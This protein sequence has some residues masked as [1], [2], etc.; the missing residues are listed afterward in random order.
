[1]HKANK[2][3]TL[4]NPSSLKEPTVLLRTER[5]WHAGHRTRREICRD[6]L[7]KVFLHQGFY[8]I[9]SRHSYFTHQSYFPFGLA[10]I[11]VTRRPRTIP[12][13]QGLESACR[14]LPQH[15]SPRCGTAQAFNGPMNAHL[16]QLTD[17]LVGSIVCS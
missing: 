13:S 11:A 15:H 6:L 4:C 7:I 17:K 16:A 3:S 9:K 14:I 10:P 1:M 5:W 12:Q 8:C 2:N